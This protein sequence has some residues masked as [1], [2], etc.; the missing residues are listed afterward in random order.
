MGEF[1]GMAITLGTIGAYLYLNWF[2]ATRSA[3]FLSGLFA[4][5]DDD[6]VVGHDIDETTGLASIPVT[7]SGRRFT[8]W[9]FLIFV[10]IVVYLNYKYIAEIWSVLDTVATTLAGFAARFIAPE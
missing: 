6:E 9:L 10:P 7:R 5:P 2:V 8:Y 3:W 1:I 4:K